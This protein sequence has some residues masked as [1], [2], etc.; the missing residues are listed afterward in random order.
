MRRRDK[1]T[2]ISH[3]QDTGSTRDGTCGGGDRGVR[4]WEVPEQQCPS[5]C[6]AEHE[7]METCRKAEDGFSS[8]PH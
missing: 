2:P 4:E 3:V 1:L 8:Q 5:M 6:Q 7:R